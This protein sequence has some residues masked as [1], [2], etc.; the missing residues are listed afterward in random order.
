LSG[1]HPGADH[2]A[3]DRGR[4]P[5]KSKS[6]RSSEIRQPIP[7]TDRWKPPSS[8]RR[9]CDKWPVDSYRP[10]N[11]G[12]SSSVSR[13]RRSIPTESKAD[14]K[15]DLPDVSLHPFLLRQA[16]T[17]RLQAR[18]KV[19]DADLDDHMK[20]PSHSRPHVPIESKDNFN[21]AFTNAGGPFLSQKSSSSQISGETRALGFRGRP[22][23]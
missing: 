21:R 17:N 15:R 10:R 4:S 23:R 5:R 18:S 12:T 7:S 2:A 3:Q 14:L 16:V 20:R 11:N 1:V 6:P 19:S 9:R 8:D 22:R 13:S